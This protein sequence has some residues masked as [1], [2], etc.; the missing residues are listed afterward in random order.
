MGGREDAETLLG[1]HPD[2]NAEDPH[3]DVSRK[4]AGGYP[5]LTHVAMSLRSGVSANHS[6]WSGMLYDVASDGAFSAPLRDGRIEPYEISNIVDRLGAGD[7]FAAGLI[8]ALSSPGMDSPEHAVRF[9]VAAGC[10]AHS[11]EGDFVHVTR[12]E[13][14]SLMQ[15]DSSSRVKR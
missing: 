11:I 9:A 8:F 4:L 1:I 14:E 2:T 6:L 3:L 7:A 10:L 5:K 13:I 15:G 12:A